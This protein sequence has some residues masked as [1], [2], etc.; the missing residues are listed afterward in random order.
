M[1]AAETLK[2]NSPGF[3]EHVIS[4][5]SMMS[6]LFRV[7][8]LCSMPAALRNPQQKQ[9]PGFS[10]HVISEKSLISVLCHKKSRRQTHTH[11]HTHTHTQLVN[12]CKLCLFR[13]CLKTCT[14]KHISLLYNVFLD[15]PISV[16][17]N[18]GDWG[19]RGTAQTQERTD[20]RRDT[21]DKK[22]R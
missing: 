14:L 16:L 20:A 1:P 15:T 5:K 22:H 18:V 6:V 8:T 11:T 2:K 12:F 17:Y 19:C 21:D 4:E 13:T 10:E 3:S 7:C 9:N